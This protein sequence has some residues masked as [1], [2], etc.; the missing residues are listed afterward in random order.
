MVDSKYKGCGDVITLN[1]EGG[2]I[3]ITGDC[4]IP[5]NYQIPGEWKI[6]GPHRCEREVINGDEADKTT[7]ATETSK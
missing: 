7:A 4:R 5:E 1:G 6:T 2:P 3:T